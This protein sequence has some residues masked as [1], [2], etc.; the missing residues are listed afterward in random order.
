MLWL[1]WKVNK[2]PQYPL[3]RVCALNNEIT[4]DGKDKLINFEKC[5]LLGTD[6]VG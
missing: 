6:Q 3:V 5:H 4:G 1:C 2:D